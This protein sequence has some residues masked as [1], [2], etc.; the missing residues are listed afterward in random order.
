[1]LGKPRNFYVV[2]LNVEK[3]CGHIDNRHKQY[4]EREG[5]PGLAQE[6]AQNYGEEEEPG[7]G[8]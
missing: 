4:T 3:V 7:G 8:R 5:L 6:H 2:Q 1:M